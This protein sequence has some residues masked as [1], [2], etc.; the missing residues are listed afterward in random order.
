MA[1]KIC[2]YSSEEVKKM[3]TR[4]KLPLSSLDGEG[5]ILSLESEPKSEA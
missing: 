1:K 3:S 5:T 4:C 2:I